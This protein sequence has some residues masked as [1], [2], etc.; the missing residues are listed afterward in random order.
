M[1]E[2]QKIWSINDLPDSEQPG[3][4][5]ELVDNKRRILQNHISWIDISVLKGTFCSWI[6]GKMKEVSLPA[7]ELELTS[8]RF[9]TNRIRVPRIIE[10]TGRLMIENE[11][12]NPELFRINSTKEK[13]EELTGLIDRVVHAQI[14]AQQGI[15][16]IMEEF[17]MVDIAEAYKALFKR[18]DTPVIPKQMVKMLIRV[19]GVDNPEEK[20][21]CS[22]ALMFSLPPLNR[23]I[24]ETCIFV[25]TRVAE[26]LKNLGSLKS[27]S[28]SGLAIVMMPNLL[29]AEA[30]TDNYSSV[31]E[32]TDYMCYVFENFERLTSI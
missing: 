15:H 21:V 24:L 1:F 9:S 16:Q 25:C 3:I 11:L 17:T 19:E 27:M 5:N 30:I 29:P 14:S 22:R 10:F 12:E 23:R 28:L 32:I 13:V 31:K 4:A 26:K 6:F 2:S 7:T 8:L 18:L 20:I